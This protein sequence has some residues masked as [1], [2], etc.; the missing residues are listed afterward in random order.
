MTLTIGNERVPLALDAEGVARVGGTRVTLDTVVA[1]FREGA[2]AEEIVQ[3]FPTLLLADVSSV[4]G[5]YLRRRSEVET[6]VA[7]QAAFQDQVRSE[8]EL[9]F[10]PEGI[11]ERLLRRL[12]PKR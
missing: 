2:T 9:R 7:E 1:A 8:N 5:F 6:Y 4:L 12:P 10:P 3:R 11:R